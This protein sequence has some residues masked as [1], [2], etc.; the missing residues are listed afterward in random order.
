MKEDSK[1]KKVAEQI[2][3]ILIKNEMALQ[4]FMNRS[5]QGTYAAVR[6]VSTKEEP[7]SD[8]QTNDANQSTD[9]TE[10]K[11]VG[12]KVGAAGDSQS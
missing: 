2:E 8:N 10:D 4:P 9:T 12:E 5:I 7:V 6:L 3:K 1:V 11:G